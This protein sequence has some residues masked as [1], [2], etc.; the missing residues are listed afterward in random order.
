M[1]KGLRSKVTVPCVGD[2]VGCTCA[3]I[4]HAVLGVDTVSGAF[5]STPEVMS[6]FT[7]PDSPAA[8][9]AHKAVTS[10]QE[11]MARNYETV[12]LVKMK[13]GAPARCPSDLKLIIKWA[14]RERT[15]LTMSLS[16]FCI[17]RCP[18]R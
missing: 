14:A 9:A 16:S 17:R 3:Q 2:K 1:V 10:P 6:F 5:G 7:S 13:L 11:T 8:A 15:L 18:R 4:R 12:W